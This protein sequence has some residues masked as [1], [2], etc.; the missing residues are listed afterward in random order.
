MVVMLSH[1]HMHIPYN[2]INALY[3]QDA[4]HYSQTSSVYASFENQLCSA[5]S[6][7]LFYDP[8]ASKVAINSIEIPFLLSPQPINLQE[9]SDLRALEK[10]HTDVC[11][12]R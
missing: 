11:L 12:Y 10:P 7:F 3:I 6:L 4:C 5:T 8:F 2:K 1:A 9:A